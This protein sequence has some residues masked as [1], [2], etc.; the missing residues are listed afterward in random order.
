LLATACRFPAIR[1]R[2]C[3]HTIELKQTTDFNN[4]NELLIHKDKLEV[5]ATAAQQFG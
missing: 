4:W 1:C 2:F 3:P 5:N